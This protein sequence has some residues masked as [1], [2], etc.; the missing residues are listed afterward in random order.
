MT[1]RHMQIFRVLC[2][3]DYNTTKAAQALNMTQ[4]AVSLAIKELEQHYNVV[5]FDRVG[6][7]LAIT[8]AG[9]R[10][11]EY[12]RSIENI[13]DDMETEMKN[14]DKH[15]T[16]RVGGTLTI[17]S[18]FMPMYAKAF[19]ESYP[20]IKIKGICAPANMLE[21]KILDNELDI[22]FS[23][24]VAKDPMIVSDAYMD[25]HLI[26]FAPA[27]GKYSFGQTISVEEFCSN[28]L[29]LREYGS[30]TRK[31]FDMACEKIGFK[32]EPAWE[33]MSTTG[34]INAVVQGIG[35]GVLSYRLVNR[36]IENGYVVPINVEGL[37]LAR[38]FYIIRHRDKKLSTAVKYFLYL[39]NSTNFE[40]PENI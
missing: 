1:L 18:C 14:W 8:Q 21:K 15:G 32:A 35:L 29:V 10:F 20:H 26:V 23:E 11:E 5:L 2:E 9:K 19:A 13:F 25:D 34:I 40:V 28:N 22:A 3:N 39:C 17:G 30:G 12:C 36:A 33:S 37:D 38:K 31:I 6:R 16:I 7:R 4:P 27:D 24:G